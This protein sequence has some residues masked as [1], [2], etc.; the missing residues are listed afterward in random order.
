MREYG[1]RFRCKIGPKLDFAASGMKKGLI[2]LYME[3]GVIEWLQMNISK[4][5]IKLLYCNFI[6]NRQM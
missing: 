6:P 3:K 5:Q 2:K 1:K 4:L